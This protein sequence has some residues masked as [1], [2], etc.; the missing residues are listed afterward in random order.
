MNLWEENID[1]EKK[2][3]IK[4]DLFYGFSRYPQ[5]FYTLSGVLGIYCILKIEKKIPNINFK[6]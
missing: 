6:T 1:I 2:K 3:K 4:L 5:K